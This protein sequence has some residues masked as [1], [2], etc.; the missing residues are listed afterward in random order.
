MHERVG[1]EQGEAPEGFRLTVFLD[2]IDAEQRRRLKA[3]PGGD[4]GALR[5]A[6]ENRGCAVVFVGYWII[7]PIGTLPHGRRVIVPDTVLFGIAW[8]V[9]GAAI[10]CFQTAL[11]YSKNRIQF[12]RPLASFQLTQQKLAEMFTEI[13]KGQA[14]DAVANLESVKEKLT[15]KFGTFKIK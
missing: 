8:G 12:N 2:T 9:L 6:A 4:I 5:Q 15:E 11:D 1:H 10:D 14:F 3:E 13:T 7:W